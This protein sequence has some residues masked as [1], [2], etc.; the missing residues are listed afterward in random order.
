MTEH[1]LVDISGPVA[2]ATFNRPNAR[3]AMTWA[4]YEGLVEFCDRV[5]RDPQIRVAVLRGAGSD[6]F[7]AGTDISQFQDFDAND[8]V[9]YERHITSVI[10]RL[11]A[12]EVPTIA[13]IDGYATGGGFIIA[14]AC[15]L[16]LCTPA[17]KFGLP[18][19]RTL[20]N[21]LSMQAYA[22]LTS[23]IGH[24]RVL[25][26][27]YTA[28]FMGAEEALRTGLASE[29]V[30]AELLEDRIAEL[31]ERIS[32]HAPLTMQASKLALARLRDST[33]VPSGQ[34]LIEMCYGS[35]DFREGVQAFL[36]KRTPRWAGH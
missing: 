1:L 35:A 22:L 2:V 27:I 33:S 9:D 25:H 16:R 21:C 23:L 29:L 15:D 30:P 3:N 31:C 28:E 13:A 20:G 34:E 18:I 7:V 19:A 10:N 32:A 11:A 24:A 26:L 4:M 8:G 12:V 14:A 17:A 36:E 6:A 5:D